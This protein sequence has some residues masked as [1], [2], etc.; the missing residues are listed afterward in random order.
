MFEQNKKFGATSFSET[1]EEPTGQCG[2][3]PAFRGI[4]IPA[5]LHQSELHDRL[6]R[7]LRKY[8]QTIRSS[9]G[10][11]FVLSLTPPTPKQ[12]WWYYIFQQAGLNDGSGI[13][14]EWNEKITP[15]YLMKTWSAALRAS[16]WAEGSPFNKLIT[17]STT[18]GDFGTTLNVLG[19]PDRALTGT[20]SSISGETWEYFPM[21][22]NV[23]TFHN[24]GLQSL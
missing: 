17:L 16:D 8:S 9:A 20:Q 3:A 2:W 1:P 6:S 12:C 4:A 7:L 22:K 5:A 11:K 18:P 14:K 24:P 19:R 21:D 10:V 15:I 23:R 13:I